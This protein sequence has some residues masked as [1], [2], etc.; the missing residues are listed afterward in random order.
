[1]KRSPTTRTP[2]SRVAKGPS[3]ARWTAPGANTT[4]ITACL[5]KRGLVID[6]ETL[7]LDRGYDNGRTRNYVADYGIDDLICAK[8]QP[9][10][11]A[12]FKLP[13]PIG[14][15]WPVCVAHQQL[16]FELRSTQPQHLRQINASFRVFLI[17]PLW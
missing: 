6:I 7:Q 4:A 12:E 3:E 8:K 14:M 5:I 11:A 16:A 13:V 10:G 17:T 9:P 15:R 2:P 1:M